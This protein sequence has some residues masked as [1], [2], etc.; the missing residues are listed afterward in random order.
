MAENTPQNAALD[1]LRQ[2]FGLA[3]GGAL[4][5]SDLD[6]VA[7][8]LVTSGNHGMASHLYNTWLNSTVSPLAYVVQA[9][10]GD[11][12]VLAKDITGA[13]QAFRRSLTLNGAYMRAQTALAK[14]TG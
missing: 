6:A 10:L 9:D 3:G 5:Y 1:T 4:S 12:L 2:V 13:E 14:L 8:L 7:K 11:V